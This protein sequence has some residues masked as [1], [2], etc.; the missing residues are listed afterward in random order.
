MTKDL[1]YVR[2]IDTN[3]FL[4]I[5]ITNRPR[6]TKATQ[7]YQQYSYGLG[8]I[9]PIIKEIN[10]K[11][12]QCASIFLTIL[13]D[14]TDKKEKEWNNADI[15]ERKKIINK[16]YQ[17]YAQKYSRDKEIIEYY[18]TALS[19]EYIGKDANGVKNYVK[20]READKKALINVLAMHLNGYK[21][22]FFPSSAIKQAANFEWKAKSKITDE[23]A[24]FNKN[25]VSN[26]LFILLYLMK[27]VK[28]GIKG[29]NGDF[30]IIFYTNDN[31]FLR[32]GAQALLKYDENEMISFSKNI[33]LKK[34]Y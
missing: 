32:N 4:D 11:S 17:K 8:L 23:L 1:F 19:Q 22:Y 33:E 2:I 30:K 29:L 24:L 12:E 27:L 34:P 26:D 20:E 21:I 16:T 6:N 15:D 18:L 28:F 14:I 3:V 31:D 9:P 10:S 13:K 25:D 5:I 7:F